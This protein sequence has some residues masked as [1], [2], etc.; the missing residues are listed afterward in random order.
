MTSPN[1]VENPAAQQLKDACWAGDL[2]EVRRLLDSGVDPNSTDEHG[3]GTLL[4]FHPAVTE[5]LLSRGADP[6]VQ[7][8]EN[9]ASVLAGLAF[10]N[11]LECV[12]ILLRA[13]ADPNRGRR[14]H[15][16]FW[17]SVFFQSLPLP[18]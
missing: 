2:D 8:N 17:L 6:N 13:G 12:R 9:G 5:Y 4:N 3:C 18:R 16:H 1:T 11:E 14:S 15:S 10:V 7:V